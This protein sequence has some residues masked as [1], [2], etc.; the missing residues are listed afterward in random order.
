MN[1]PLQPQDSGEPVLDEGEQ[2]LSRRELEPV[3][4]RIQSL[5]SFW[6]ITLDELE[7]PTPPPPSPAGPLPIKY[8][9]PVSGETWD[10]QGT[11]PEWLRHALLKEGLRV[12]ELKPGIADKQ[13]PAP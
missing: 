5:M 3:I 9:H 8:R 1:E 6:G 2:R 10:G 11:H 4:A 13:P 12:E 7:A